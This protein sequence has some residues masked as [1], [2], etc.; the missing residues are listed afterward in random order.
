MTPM[1]AGSAL[2]MDDNEFNRRVNTIAALSAINKQD[3]AVC[4]LCGAAT[5]PGAGM[6]RH[7]KKF[8]TQAIRKLPAASGALHR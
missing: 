8:H 5:K 6:R 2:T 3:K 7:L 4:Q 1:P